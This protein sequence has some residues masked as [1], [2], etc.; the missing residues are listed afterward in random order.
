M[1]VDSTAT[2]GTD[3]CGYVVPNSGETIHPKSCKSG[4]CSSLVGTTIHARSS[5]MTATAGMIYG[6]HLRHS[7]WS[8]YS[9]L[10]GGQARR[11]R[12]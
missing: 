3:E 2:Y 10:V 7:L 4:L 1:Y 8:S 12:L 6:D 9:T 11:S 5:N